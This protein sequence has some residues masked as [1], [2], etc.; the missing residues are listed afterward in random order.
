MEEN[1]TYTQSERDWAMFCHLSA[2]AGYLIPFGGIIGPLIF[3]TSR[4]DNSE[5][6]NQNGRSSMNFQ[7]SM[8]LYL[9]LTIPLCIILIGIPI[10][11]FL[12]IF[13]LVCIVVASI[14][15]SHGEVFK[16]PLSIPFIQ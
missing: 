15:A 12:W 14:K 11:I 3:W 2:V 10:L 7:L 6:V 4:K 16:Y 9:V 1:K 13:R 5:W 8:L